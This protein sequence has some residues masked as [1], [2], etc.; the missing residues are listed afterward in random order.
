VNQQDVQ[1][2]VWLGLPVLALVGANLRLWQARR[3]LNRVR[4]DG[5]APRSRPV[6]SPAVA[7]LT[8]SLM[9]R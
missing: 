8:S 4:C 9:A 1:L 2:I 3:I 7:E 6:Q 5:D